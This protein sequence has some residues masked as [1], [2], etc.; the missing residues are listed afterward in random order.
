MTIETTSITSG[1]YTGNGLLDTYAYTFPITA[2]TEITVYETDA[3]GV[4]TVLVLNTDYTVTGAGTASGTAIR[5]AGNLPTGYTWYIRS[6]IPLTQDTDF[7]S[8]GGFFPE[9]HE[10]ALDKLTLIS[11]QFQD[12]ADRSLRFN[13]G[14][15]GSFDTELPSPEPL[16]FFKVNV[17]GDGLQLAGSTTI[18]TSTE[19]INALDNATIVTVTPATDDNIL[20]KD[21]SDSAKVKKVT[22][23]SILDLVP[24]PADELPDQSGEAGKFLTTNGTAASW[25]SSSI[26]R[27]YTAEGAITTGKAVFLTGNDTVT[28]SAI[29]NAVAAGAATTIDTSATINGGPRIIYA[30]A[31]DRWV[32]F[33]WDT[34]DNKGYANI[35]TSDGETITWG[36]QIEFLGAIGYSPALIQACWDSNEEQIIM[37]YSGVGSS[38]IVRT[39]QVVLGSPD[40]LTFGPEASNLNGVSYEVGVSYD[41]LAN[42]ALFAW[43]NGNTNHQVAVVSISGDTLS[44]GSPVTIYAGATNGYTSQSL[45]IEDLGLHVVAYNIIGQGFGVGVTIDPSTFAVTVGTAFNATSGGGFIHV[46]DPF[47]WSSA[48]Q[49]L[50]VV[51]DEGGAASYYMSVKLFIYVGPGWTYNGATYLDFSAF[52]TPSRPMS[53]AVDN[54]TDMFCVGFAD[55]ASGF[56]YCGLFTG[57]IGSSGVTI[58]VGQFTVA[59][60][61]SD[62]VNVAVAPNKQFVIAWEFDATNAKTRIFDQ[63][64][65][66]NRKNVIGFANA[67]VADGETVEVI[68]L[69]SIATTAQSNLVAGG[70]YQISSSDGFTLDLN[71]GLTGYFVLRAINATQGIVLANVQEVQ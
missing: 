60:E 41:T 42:K 50:L 12:Y 27:D 14:Y 4:E 64:I 18:V 30:P 21:T 46:G 53:I 26:G 28:Q 56:W 65:P 38:G 13:D 7:N 51:C 32:A 2:D 36:A 19:V 47:A 31:Q 39:C 29:S 8:Q 61:S 17:A 24:A 52:S 57:K 11:Q 59:S 69:G 45:F 44:I 33:Y 1:P 15:S 35:G 66:D 71:T 37:A 70:L 63:Q 43:R 25:G 54:S 49:R 40:T 68:N 22:V 5:T 20:I 9:I 48:N 10:A 3:D 34:T 23:Q 58:N 62:F 67:T 6:N 16:M 55:A